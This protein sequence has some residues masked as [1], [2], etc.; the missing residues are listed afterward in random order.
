MPTG[1]WLHFLGI[2]NHLQIPNK[3][4]KPFFVFNVELI[5]QMLDWNEDLN[6]NAGAFEYASIV[7]VIFRG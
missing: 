5:H 2:G 7:D 3:L 6:C 1:A 4:S